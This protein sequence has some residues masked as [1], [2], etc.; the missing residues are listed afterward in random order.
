MGMRCFWVQ[1]V[2]EKWILDEAY[3]VLPKSYLAPN[4]TPLSAFEGGLYLLCNEKK[5]W[6]TDKQGTVMIANGGW[7]EVEAI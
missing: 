3:A 2:Q 1:Y 5:E 7:E 6:E 4:L